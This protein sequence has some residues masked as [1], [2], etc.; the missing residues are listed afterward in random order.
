M[1]PHL[2]QT[3][4][5]LSTLIAQAIATRHFLSTQM[6]GA[7]VA[8]SLK[9]EAPL[10]TGGEL[11]A[12]AAVIQG[13]EVGGRRTAGFVPPTRDSPVVIQG[14]RRRTEDGGRKPKA[15][16][17][18]AA[19]GPESETDGAVLWILN[20]FERPKAGTRRIAAAIATLP[21]LF[22]AEQAGAAMGSKNPKSTYSALTRLTNNG[23][24]G[25]TAAG[26]WC[27]LDPAARPDSGKVAVQA[28]AAAPVVAAAPTPM[29]A[30]ASELA[31]N[32]GIVRDLPE[33][34]SATPAAV[35]LGVDAKKA[36]LILEAMRERGW[37][38]C[39]SLGLYRRTPGYGE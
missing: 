21:T 1:T 19:A 28:A 7:P 31:R 8:A 33:P 12:A 27:R 30:G 29:G 35:A 18:K 14:G 15:P 17:A 3:I 25:K 16:A 4:D 24:I 13:E 34:F 5:E 38:E 9:E 39:P 11:L 23:A 22:T 2:Q 36:R 37:L 6:P 26:P 20:K 10:P 32:V